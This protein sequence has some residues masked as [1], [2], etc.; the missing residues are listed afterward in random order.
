MPFWIGASRLES[1]RLAERER[2]A[3]V[4]EQYLEE[5]KTWTHRD[6][7]G[8]SAAARACVVAALGEV[9]RRIRARGDEPDRARGARL[10]ASG[11]AR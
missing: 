10:G 1:A 4:P 8:E 9:A 6:D 7:H 11:S 2:C 3:Q 5:M